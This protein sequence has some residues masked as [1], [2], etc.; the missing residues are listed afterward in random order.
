MPVVTEKIV[1]WPA[2][3]PYSKQAIPVPGTKR[4]GQSGNAPAHHFNG[5]ECCFDY[6]PFE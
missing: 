2:V 4:P 5:F 1:D 6:D 3:K